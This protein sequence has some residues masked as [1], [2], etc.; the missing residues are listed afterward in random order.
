MVF[1]RVKMPTLRGQIAAQIREAILEG[2]LR[3]GEKIVERK[4]SEQ[5]GASLTAIRE[6]IITLESEGF[7]SKKPNAA[8][9]ITQLDLADVESIFAVR[10]LLEPFAMAQAARLA[11][12]E[13][14]G[15]LEKRYLETV[16]AARHGKVRL[17]MQKDFAWHAAVW[18]VTGN[19]YLQSA[20]R[21]VTL[22]LFSFSAI[23]F[24]EG[25]SFDL[26][27]DA[28]S[29]VP[30][31][32]AIKAHKPEEAERLVLQAIDIWLG[33]I[34]DFLRGDQS[35]TGPKAVKRRKSGGASPQEKVQ[36]G[37]RSGSAESQ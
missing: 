20:L 25:D 23:R 4:L 2:R 27:T 15:G 21:R 36:P 32:E 5:F 3:P 9:Y 13:Q 24:S 35:T 12:A 30:V 28:N 16:D 34:R 14:L 37:R 18:D 7:V 8:T 29:H 11:S 26:L 10:R 19:E 33:E 6:A 22:P 17:Y 31:L 1:E